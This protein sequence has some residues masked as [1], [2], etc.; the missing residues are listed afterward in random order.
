MEVLLK[1][2]QQAGA[3]ALY[4]F[5][6]MRSCQSDSSSRFPAIPDGTSKEFQEGGVLGVPRKEVGG[7]L[8]MQ[9]TLL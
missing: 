4:S 2:P 7:S 6:L 1:L 5:S 3:A 9:W 8:P